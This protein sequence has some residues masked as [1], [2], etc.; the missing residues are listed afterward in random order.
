MKNDCIYCLVET[1]TKIADMKHPLFFVDYIENG[2]STYLSAED[3]EYG[4]QAGDA[5]N[6]PGR[7]RVVGFRITPFLP[8]RRKRKHD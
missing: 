2:Y 6:E 5:Y 3:A 4:R 1:D 7:T 8:K